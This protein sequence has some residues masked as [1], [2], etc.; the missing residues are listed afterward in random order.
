MSFDFFPQMQCLAPAQTGRQTKATH[1]DVPPLPSPF[2][3][4]QPDET[5][6]P[7]PRKMIV[8]GGASLPIGC[9]VRLH[10]LVGDAEF[11]GLTAVVVGHR[12]DNKVIA[13]FN[14]VVDSPKLTA[15]RR[16]CVNAQ[17]CVVG[18]NATRAEL[19][20]DVPRVMEQLEKLMRDP[21][22]IKEDGVGGINIFAQA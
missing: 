6:T 20:A 4:S 16:F 9:V 11:N 10:G 15:G 1:Y 2:V 18:R 21:G 19:D 3:I 8:E 22:A 13:K 12:A 5:A 14:T 7:S 17:F